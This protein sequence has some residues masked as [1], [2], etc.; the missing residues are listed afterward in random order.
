V[1]NRE[2]TALFLLN[3]S[4]AI[5]VRD[6]GVAGSN[7]ATPTKISLGFLPLFPNAFKVNHR[8]DPAAT[9]WSMVRLQ[10][11]NPGGGRSNLF[12]YDICQ[13]IEARHLARR[14]SLICF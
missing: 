9:I 8:F 4:I 11:T 7:P 10:T 1:V 3:F 12:G 13:S 5:Y 6:A 2:Q 14:R